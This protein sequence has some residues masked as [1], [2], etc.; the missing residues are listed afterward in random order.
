MAMLIKEYILKK[1][2][3]HVQRYTYKDIYCGIAYIG[4]K[5]QTS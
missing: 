2:Y 4:K 1:Y 3:T 5:V